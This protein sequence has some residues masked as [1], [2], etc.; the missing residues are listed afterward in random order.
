MK[1]AEED[2]KRISRLEDEISRLR[3]SVQELSILNE[4]A[5]AISSTLLSVPQKVDKK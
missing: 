4:I 5:V 1:N 2:L 3:I